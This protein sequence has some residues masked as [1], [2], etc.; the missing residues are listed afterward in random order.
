MIHDA[1]AAFFEFLGICELEDSP[2]GYILADLQVMY[3]DEAFFG[4][5]LRFD[6]VIS[7]ISNRSC[8]ILYQTSKHVK[9]LNKTVVI[10]KAK[11]GVVFYDYDLRQAIPV[12]NALTRLKIVTI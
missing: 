12:P 1:R 6:I 2:H 9:K 3:L 11:T 8:Q 10:A 7:E 5:E 4:D